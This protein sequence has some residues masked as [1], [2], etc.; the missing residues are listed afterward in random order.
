MI[1]GTLGGGLEFAVFDFGVVGTLCL[2][3]QLTPAIKRIPS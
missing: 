1:L 2:V 3:K